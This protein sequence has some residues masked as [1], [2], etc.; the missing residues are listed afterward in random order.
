MADKKNYWFL[1]FVL[2]IVAERCFGNNQVLA[3]QKMKDSGAFKHFADNY[4]VLHTQGEEYLMDI[5]QKF[6]KVV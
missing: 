5:V 2:R 3:Y 6:I 1:V 4:D